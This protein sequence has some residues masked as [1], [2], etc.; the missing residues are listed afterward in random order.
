MMSDIL[1][2]ALPSEVVVNYHRQ[3]VSS[4]AYRSSGETQNCPTSL[5]SPAVQDTGH[6]VDGPLST[7]SAPVPLSYADAEGELADILSFIRIE[8]ESRERVGVVEERQET[9]KK[10][11]EGPRMPAASVLHTNIRSHRSFCR[12]TKYAT[13]V[14]TGD[15]TLDVKKKKLAEEN[16]CFRCTIGGQ[17][18]R[19]SETQPE[20]IE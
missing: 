8:V 10:R 3:Q 5:S 11:P 16:R 6:P 13:E 2:K 18:A 19:V 14:C 17:R 7:R 15:L 4:T 9:Q 20:E 1:L 12:S